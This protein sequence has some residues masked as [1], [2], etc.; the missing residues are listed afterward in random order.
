METEVLSRV[1][2]SGRSC[3]RN[4][5]PFEILKTPVKLYRLCP[6]RERTK[7]GKGTTA[8]RREATRWQ[9]GRG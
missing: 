9:P 7:E 2:V 1:A 8:S 6:K 4:R 3:R 5:T